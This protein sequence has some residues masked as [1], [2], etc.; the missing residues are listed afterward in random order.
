MFYNDGLTDP[1]GD[2]QAM[3][4]HVADME[5]RTGLSLKAKIFWARGPLLGRRRL[6]CVGIALGSDSSPANELDRHELAHAII[7]QHSPRDSDPPTLL[8]EGWAESQA[9]DSKD[10]AE[11]ALGLRWHLNQ[12]A[13]LPDSE[14]ER[15]LA[16]FADREGFG[17]LVQRTRESQPGAGMYFRELTGSFWY[18]RDRGAV[19]ELG[20]ALVNFLLRKYGAEHFVDFY[21]AC[22]PGTFEVEC[23]GVFGTDLDALEKAFWEDAER[24]AGGPIPR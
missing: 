10:L 16:H 5:K 17:R 20:G 13:T 21:F 15:E 14:A 24:L 7:N 23:R 4:Q 2:L 6:C 22:Q 3:D 9:V 18:H 8:S 11:R 12:M 19:Y 1:E